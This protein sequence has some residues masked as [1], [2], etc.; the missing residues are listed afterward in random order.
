MAEKQKVTFVRDYEIQDEHAGTDKATW[1]REGETKTLTA[2]SAEHFF[3][4]G[5]AVMARGAKAKS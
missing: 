2:A 3:N 1:F 4:R 5:A